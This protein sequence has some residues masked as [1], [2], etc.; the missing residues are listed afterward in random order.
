[1]AISIGCGGRIWR[2]TLTSPLPAARIATGR[3]PTL[4]TPPAYSIAN[5]MPC[6]SQ[7]RQ[8][9]KSCFMEYKIKR[10]NP[11]RTVSFYLV[12]GAGFEPTTSRL[13]IPLRFSP[14]ASYDAIRGLDYTFILLTVELGCLP[15]SLYTF[16]PS[17]YGFDGLGSVLPFQAS[18]NLTGNLLIGFLTRRP[19]LLSLASYRAAP[20]REIFKLCA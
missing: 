19:L 17:P 15:S 12:A 7:K 10:D 6:L 14:L 20:P 13:C 16:P 3:P 8:T 9:F 11:F 1:M 5:L 18:P 4:E 2:P